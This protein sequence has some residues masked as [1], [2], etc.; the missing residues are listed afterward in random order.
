MPPYLTITTKLSFPII[1]PG[2]FH[3][4]SLKKNTFSPCLNSS[5][6]GLICFLSALWILSDD[7]A[8]KYAFFASCKP[9]HHFTD[10]L[11]SRASGL[12]MILDDKF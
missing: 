11:F 1:Q 9:F 7:S 2:P 12:L 4:P 6:F 8:A 5:P 3:S 10:N